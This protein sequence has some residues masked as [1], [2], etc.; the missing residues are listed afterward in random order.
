[1]DVAEA[2]TEKYLRHLGF[3]NIV[4]EPDGNVS[5]DFVLNGRIAVEV[6]RLLHRGSEQLRPL[7]ETAIP[8]MQ[9]FQK[10]LE[11]LGPPRGSEPS[12]FVFLRF[13]RPIENW[14]TLRPKLATWL[15]IFRD[16]PSHSR[17]DVDFGGRLSISVFPA[18][19][20]LATFF[21]IGG[22]SDCEGGGMVLS[23]L[24]TNIPL[25]IADK[26][27]KIEKVRSRYPEW[28][29]VLTDHIA[30]RLDDLDRQQFRESVSI[31]HSW[32]R[33]VLLNPADHRDAFE[34]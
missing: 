28:W 32:D 23:E 27:R 21:R 15:T 33:V 12:W 29:L 6:T 9:R 8:L 13:Q 30:F 19:K 34:V 20:S 25:C 26:T 22:S 5:P 14:R 1:M 10:V 11:S 4:H 17:Q 2:H 18:S 7:E 24:S 16:A 31:A 3:T